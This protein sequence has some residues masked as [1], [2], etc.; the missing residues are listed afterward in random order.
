MK[1]TWNR[2]H[3]ILIVHG[4]HIQR[5]I[6]R[7]SDTVVFVRMRIVNLLIGRQAVIANVYVAKLGVLEVDTTLHFFG[8]VTLLGNNL[9]A[10]EYENGLSAWRKK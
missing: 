9:P 5:V 6:W 10:E 3:H 2:N 8:K 1:L 4:H 7:I